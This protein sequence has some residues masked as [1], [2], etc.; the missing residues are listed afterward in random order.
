VNNQPPSVGTAYFPEPD[1]TPN[2]TG[3]AI[4][5]GHGIGIGHSIGAGPA[6]GRLRGLPRRRRPA[7]LALAV[8][9][10]GAGVLMSAAI[11]GRT[12]HRVA[13]VMVTQPVAAG[14]MISAA[15]LGSTSVSVGSSIRVIPAAQLTQVSGEVAAVALQPAT[16]LAP[17]DL[18][19]AQPPGPGEVLVPAPVK[20]SL[21]PASGLFPGDHVL[22]VATPG[23]QGQA[24]S[25]AGSPSLTAPVGGVVE[26]VSD[27]PD[28]DGLDVVDLLV[29]DS[30]GAAVAEQVS[31]G[32]F[33][34]IVTKRGS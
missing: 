30:A 21:I 9:M 18:T 7:M 23:A 2:G 4:G 12:D 20:P 33:A 15:D 14:A 1:I 3:S 32:Q 13:V 24:G 10:A 22:V 31:T 28:A 19:T 34:L 5:T 26:A 25:S 29:S 6:P 16:L 27:V 8:A 11:Y 17:A